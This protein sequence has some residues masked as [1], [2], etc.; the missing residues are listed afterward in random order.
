MRQSRCTLANFP[1]IRLDTKC[2]SYTESLIVIPGIIPC[3]FLVPGTQSINLLFL[4]YS[5]F[6]CII[7]IA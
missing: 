6:T 3:T 1:E 5:G 2:E 7:R 4:C